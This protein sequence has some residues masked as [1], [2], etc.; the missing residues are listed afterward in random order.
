MRS[1]S[2]VFNPFVSALKFAIGRYLDSLFNSIRQEIRVTIVARVV[3]KALLGVHE[4]VLH[5]GLLMHTV[6]VEVHETLEFIL[7]VAA[8]LEF[9]LLLLLLTGL[10]NHRVN[11]CRPNWRLILPNSVAI[12]STNAITVFLNAP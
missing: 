5:F 6:N 10:F 1:N 8:V 3:T 11:I 2:L 9:R 7:R 4:K 12:L